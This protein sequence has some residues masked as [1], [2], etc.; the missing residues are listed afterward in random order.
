MLHIF[1]RFCEIGSH[2]VFFIIPFSSKLVILITIFR[3]YV[4]K[5]NDV[6]SKFRVPV[7]YKIFNVSLVALIEENGQ[8][9]FTIWKT[10]GI[11]ASFSKLS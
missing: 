2:L 10:F 3:R 8:E 11:E 6:Q 7:D 5:F 4:L 9:L 1:P